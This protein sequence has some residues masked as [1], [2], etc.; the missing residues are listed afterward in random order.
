MTRKITDKQ[1]SYLSRLRRQVGLPRY[2]AAKR[3]LGITTGGTYNLTRREAT[4]LI[5]ELKAEQTR[6][7][8]DIFMGAR[9]DDR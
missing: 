3:R 1:Q 6:L 7:A 2:N 4:I 8:M 9:N 5:N